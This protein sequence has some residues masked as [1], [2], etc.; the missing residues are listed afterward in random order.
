MGGKEYKYV[1]GPVPSRRLGSSLGV[2]LVP[3]KTCTLDC[4]YCQLACTT[5]KTLERKEYVPA[6]AVLAEVEARLA[7]CSPDYVTFSGSGEPTLHSGIGA[8]IR[9]VKKLTAAPVAVLTNGTL[10]YREDVRRALA[11]A[12]L[13]VPSLDACD[14]ETFRKINRPADGLT[15]QMLVD[16]LTAFG[17]EYKGALDL[18]VFLLK[19]VNDSEECVRR[20]GELAGRIHPRTIQLNTV[21]RP[22]AEPDAE[23]VPEEEM[24]RFAALLGESCEVI[25]DFTGIHETKE[26]AAARADV[27]TL[28][29]RRP[30][31]IRDIAAGLSIHENEAVKHVTHLLAEGL[32]TEEKRGG[33][34]YYAVE[35]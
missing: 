15:F 17:A 7:D 30:C 23:A 28:L 14:E 11:A 2:D 20:I 1:F 32:A 13:V 34:S 16:G 10:L 4:V 31:T 19:G 8:L 22:P 29:K 26:V 3:F 21:A 12:D 24:A 27:V 33:A 35:G 6:N 9:G 18:E 5:N 25:A